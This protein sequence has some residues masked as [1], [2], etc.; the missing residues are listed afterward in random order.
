MRNLLFFYKSFSTSAFDVFIEH[1]I[2]ALITT[3]HSLLN[4]NTVLPVNYKVN[5]PQLGFLAVSNDNYASNKAVG[6]FT[7]ATQYVHYV[8]FRNRSPNICCSR[9]KSSI[10]PV[11]ILYE[12]NSS[13]AFN[14]SLAVK[15]ISAHWN[16]LYGTSQ[17][18]LFILDNGNCLVKPTGA[19]SCM[20]VYH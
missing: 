10:T 8:F 12:H 16:I 7:A 15:R 19:I 14:Y 1:I 4:I 20:H 3:K 11:W 6:G 9:F 2:A 5:A 13:G 17:V 18:F